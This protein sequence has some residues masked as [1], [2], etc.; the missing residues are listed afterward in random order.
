M[1]LQGKQRW[2]SIGLILFFVLLAGLTLFSNTLE[3]A[4]LPKVTTEKPSSKRLVHHIKGSGI[5]TP[6]KVKTL[7]SDNGWLISEVHVKEKER[8]KKG[9]LLVTFDST[10]SQEELIDAEYQLKKHDLNREKLKEQYIAA[11]NAE[12]EEGMISAK[13]EL[14]IN[15]LDRNSL[16]RNIERLKRELGKSRAVHAP[17]D[18]RIIELPAERGMMIGQGQKLMTMVQLSEGYEFSF[19][20]DKD[21][22]AMLQQD[23]KI[24]VQLK[25]KESEKFTGTL[26]KITIASSVPGPND[27][28]EGEQNAPESTNKRKIIM[29][30]PAE[31]T[32]GDE[33]ASI[34]IKKEPAAQGLVIRNELI[35]RDGESNYVWVVRENR[36][37]LGTTYTVQKAYVVKGDTVEKETIILGGL[38]KD[39]ELIVESSEPLQEGN[40][41]RIK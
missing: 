2:A 33:E 19:T 14:D 22:A 36:G 35:K 30:L 8:V 16:Q 9:Q 17:F 24:P 25:G 34:A 12:D 11:G 28:G 32:E 23:E 38:L 39:D 18:G 15:T 37:T 41:I 29:T 4:M 7:N 31:G 10:K 1:L 13:R 27:K 6:K 26:S 20:L 40:R 21:A 5:L 3:T